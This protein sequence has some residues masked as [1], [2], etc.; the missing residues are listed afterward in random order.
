MPTLETTF[1]YNTERLLPPVSAASAVGPSLRYDPIYDRLR[2]LRREDDTTLPQGVWQTDQ[3]LADWKALEALC[4]E[5]L[6]KQSKDLQ[7]AAWLLEAWLHLHGFAGVSEGLAL[8]VGLCELYWVDLH[9]QIEGGDVEFRNGPLVWINNK[10]PVRLKLC[11]LTAPESNDV[12][13]FAWADWEIACQI[14]NSTKKPPPVKAQKS[15][16]SLAAFHQSVLLTPTPHFRT[17]LA[18]LEEAIVRCEKLEAL[19]DEK[20]GKDSPSLVAFRS[21]GESIADLLGS[22]LHERGH[23]ESS[24]ELT[25]LD[26]ALRDPIDGA[27]LT[28]VHTRIRTRAEAYSLLAEIADFLESTEPHSPAPHLI[29]RAFNWGSLP[30]AKLLPELVR[31]PGELSEIYRLLNLKAP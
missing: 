26:L 2:E 22:I 8:M 24:S 23:T 5:V 15:R 25:D 12:P 29:R 13:V 3:K 27:D 9:P 14:E 4:L 7:V 18:D 28:P 17:L 21:A 16:P 6:D 19:L 1:R 20:L 31:N 11:P 10:L 30:L